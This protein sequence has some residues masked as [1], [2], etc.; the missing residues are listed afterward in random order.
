MHVADL[1]A[2]IGRAHAVVL[3]QQLER[4]VQSLRD[5]GHGSHVHQTNIVEQVSIR[6]HLW[7]A[8]HDPH[9]T[10]LGVGHRVC[11]G[12]GVSRCIR[13]KQHRG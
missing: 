5:V 4:S 2:S 12:H 8:H 9:P 7:I 13:V 10:D 1:Y 6:R 3:N 11:F